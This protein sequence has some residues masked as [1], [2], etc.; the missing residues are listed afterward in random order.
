VGIVTVPLTY[1]VLKPSTDP[2][3]TAPRI[4]TDYRPEHADLVDVQKKK[5]KRRERRLK[6]AITV[7]AGWAIMAFMAYLIMVTARTIPKIWNPYDILGISEVRFAVPNSRR[8]S[9]TCMVVGD[10]ETDQ[11]TLQAHVPHV[12]SR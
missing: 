12:P 11:I 8:Q 9:L 5:Q 6:R 3:A 4:K 1:S 7:I 10:R 2:G